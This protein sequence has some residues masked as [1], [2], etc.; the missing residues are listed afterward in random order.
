MY[1]WLFV[2][3]ALIWVWLCGGSVIAAREGKINGFLA[4]CRTGVI[5]DRARVLQGLVASATCDMRITKQ[6]LALPGQS[7]T[8]RSMR[9][10]HALHFE[11]PG[12]LR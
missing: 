6:P 8:Y 5:L 1:I 3:V 9:R 4:N 7:A 12:R 2:V 11:V 10:G